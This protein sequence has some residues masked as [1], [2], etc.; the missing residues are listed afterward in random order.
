MAISWGAYEG[1]MRVGI[2]VDWDSP[3]TDS[4]IGGTAKYYVQIASDFNFSDDQVLT[5]SNPSTSGTGRSF[6]NGFGAGS[7]HLIAT[8]RFNRGTNYAGS[9][10]ANFTG[11]ISGHYAGATPS[12]STNRDVPARTPSPPGTP[13]TLS[14]SNVQATSIRITSPNVAENGDAVTTW[15]FYYSTSGSWSESTAFQDNGGRVKDIT[16]LAPGTRYYFWVRAYNSY[17]RS[18]LSPRKTAVTLPVVNVRVGGV[19][20]TAKCW[21]RKGGT[22]RPATVWVKSGGT[23]RKTV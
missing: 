8:D 11:R 17:G 1:N 22:W 19:W 10:T 6:H 5:F 9:N 7:V 21:V 2:D 13:G 3:S 4:D 16:G 12:E 14:V 20:R 15:R 18:G 23:W